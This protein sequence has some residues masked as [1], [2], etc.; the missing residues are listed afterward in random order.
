[1]CCVGL[2][3][4]LPEE[5]LPIWGGQPALLRSVLLYN[6]ASQCVFRIDRA[7][8]G[9]A[10]PIALVPST[11][12]YARKCSAYKGGSAASHVPT[13]RGERGR[14]AGVTTLT[15]YHHMI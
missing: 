8:S 2:A 4:P 6:G 3:A 12:A 1:V 13:P 9:Q 7:G 15:G 14:E 11:S 5:V 10:G